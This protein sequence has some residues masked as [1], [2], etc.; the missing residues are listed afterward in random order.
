MTGAFFQER[1]R[2]SRGKRGGRSQRSGFRAG[3]S[4]RGEAEEVQPISYD[5]VARNVPIVNY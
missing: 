2:Q 3:W 5:R 4:L 1:R